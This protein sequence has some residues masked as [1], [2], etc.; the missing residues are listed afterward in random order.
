MPVVVE[1]LPEPAYQQWV[2]DQ[3]AKTAAATSAADAK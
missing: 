1:A 3:R 2:A